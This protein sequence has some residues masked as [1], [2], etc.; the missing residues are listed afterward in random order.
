[1]ERQHTFHQLKQPCI[2]V[3][4]ATATLS[5]SPSARR[6]LIHALTRLLTSLQSI[7]STPGLLDA[8]LTEYAFVSLSQVL[9][10][11][12]HVPVRA[13][14][15]CLECISTLL[16]AN[17]GGGLEPALSGQL[18]ILFTFLAKPSS[19]ENGISASSEELQSLALGCTSK[20][21]GATSRTK[22]GQEAMTAAANIPALGEAVLVMLERLTDSNSNSVKLQ[23]ACALKGT[24]GAIGDDDALASFLPRIV[25]SLAKV[26]TPH[27]SIRPGFRVVEQGLEVLTS[28][29]VRLL[30]DAQT[31]DLPETLL[32]DESGGC[33]TISRSVAWLQATATQIKIALANIF[34]LRDHDKQEVRQALLNLCLCIVR[35]C[36]TSL[37]LCTSMA[38]ETMVDLA[39]HET[40]G[41]TTED[42]LKR[43]LSADQNLSELLRES[44]HGWIV[45]LPRLMQSK[46]DRTRHKIVHQISVSLRLFD[47][48]PMILDERLADSLRD[49]VS[50]VFI[51][52][53][54][55]EEINDRNTSLIAD[56]TLVFSSTE[57]SSFP[58]ISMQFKGQEDMMTGFK[59]LVQELA[60]SNSALAVVQGLT[61]S[62]DLG[63][64]EMR[65]ASFW[66]SV[67]LVRDMAKVNPSVDDFM[68]LGTPNP[69]EEVLDDLYSHSLSLLNQRSADTKS[70]WHL[71][72]LALETV[73]LQAKRYKT[74][75]RPELSEVLYPVLHYL[76]SSNSA[77]R[78]HALTC[79]NI[80]AGAS[81]YKD[82]GELVVSNVDYIVNAVGLKLAYGDVSPQA[83]Q[84]LLMMIRLCGPSLLPYL[85]DLVDSI[86]NALER[87]HGYPKLVELLFNVLKGMAE[88]GV[89]APQLALSVDNEK[90]EH[91]HLKRTVII[92]DVIE[93][94]LK[95]ELDAQEREEEEKQ[96]SKEAL[97]RKP[98]KA[99][100]SSED[101]DSNGTDEENGRPPPPQTEEPPPPA[102]R[103]FAIL[104]KISEL[105]QH[106]LTTMSPN[107]R[108][109]LL[110]LLR[111][112]IPAIAGH[113]NSLLPLINT[114]W[115][116]LLPRL[117][118]SEAYVV[119]NALDIVALMCEH[120]KDFMRTR[121]D[122]AWNITRKVY[123]RTRQND[124]CNRKSSFQPISLEIKAIE[125][126]LTRLAVDSQPTP[127]FSPLELYVDAPTR[128]IWSSLTALLCAI[129]KHVT[130]RDEH[131]E[132]MLDMLDPVLARDDV[133]G[134]L[135][136][137]NA[138]AIWL[139]LY[140]KQQGTDREK[141]SRS[142]ISTKAHELPGKIPVGKPHWHF[143]RA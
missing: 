33:T 15:L 110:S 62:V 121:I 26:L 35:D 83:P 16:S 64:P 136:H 113:E 120:G 4:Q 37:S 91:V 21:M 90:E 30:G 25:S 69:R 124:D 17:W 117:Q 73:A 72:A 2:Q 68:D 108:N 28:L 67:N 55:L 13:L 135:D 114:L 20:L 7:T 143:V 85:D 86:F 89:K 105:T 140:K 45:A 70:S 66:L 54:G 125:T 53:R 41:D 27:S 130:M 80:V 99:G 24:V 5:Q 39:G 126:G 56:R 88:Q 76:G 18:L 3:L 48:D 98:W 131:F 11:S 111:T 102:P 122:N 82:A 46:D 127:D 84:V 36:R 32:S 51:D 19:A 63:A 23:S 44:L 104:L 95:L 119:S 34:R 94:I 1:M 141:H 138:D 129:A 9:R 74:E 8:K 50:A 93:A 29:L 57:S 79:L 87:Y 92:N 12:R 71:Y 60:R 52:G 38:I 132:E 58:P 10:N 61:N 97:P 115:P 142:F 100:K 77:L 106:Y 42:K 134:A 59:V 107:L 49:G 78:E 139:R 123:E 103:A 40:P 81:G 75:F 109:S 65:L 112:T 137:S 118:D 31:K 43:L 101:T 22:Q 116:V 96:A 133:R 128:M 6:E 47:D 14:E